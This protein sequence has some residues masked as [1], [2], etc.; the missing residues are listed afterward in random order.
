MLVKLLD[1]K[2]TRNLFIEK[3]SRNRMLNHIF[4]I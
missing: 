2:Q 4:K 1:K 3:K